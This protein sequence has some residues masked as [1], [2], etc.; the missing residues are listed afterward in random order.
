M[1]FSGQELALPVGLG[2]GGITQVPGLSQSAT[3]SVGRGWKAA[4]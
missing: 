3:Q 4:F 1:T 2:Y